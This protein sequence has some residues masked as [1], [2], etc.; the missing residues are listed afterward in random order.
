MKTAL[1]AALAVTLLGAAPAIAQPAFQPPDHPPQGPV[2][3]P[4]DHRPGEQGPG[5]RGPGDR[6]AGQWRGDQGQSGAERPR[7]RGGPRLSRGD[8]LPD[9]F[10]QQ[11]YAVD[12]WRQQGLR[13]PP[14]GYRWMRDDNNDF[15]LAAIATGLI[16]ETLYRDERDVRWNQRYRRTYDY[17][18][19]VYYRECHDRPDPAGV[20]IGSL[21]GGLIGNAAAQGRNQPAATFAGV[22]IGGA[23]G[24][25]MSRNLDCEDRSYAYR[26]YYDGF[27]GGDVGRWREWRNP[28]NAHRGAFRVDRFDN[29]PGGF[30]CAQFTQRIWVDGRPQDTR[31]RACRQPDG[32]WAGMD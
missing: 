6:G 32:V 29:D 5:D 4:G 25:S 16:G 23:L 31:G 3:A 17:N 14:R 26:S 9:Q 8:R 27:N 1:T 2:G 7:Y 13:A 19:D 30:R 20:I 10:R 21:I 22:V 18:D 11:R 15:F 12:D 28:R 24:A